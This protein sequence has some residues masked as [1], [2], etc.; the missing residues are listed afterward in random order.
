MTKVLIRKRQRD[1]L[2][3]RGG[4]N[5]TMEAKTGVTW[6]QVKEHFTGDRSWKK[7]SDF[8]IEP[9]EGLRTC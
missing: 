7:Q 1:S 2:D 6:L 5:V 9:L 3:R 8:P 4:S